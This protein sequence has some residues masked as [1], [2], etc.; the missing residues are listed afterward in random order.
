L[1]ECVFSDDEIV[2]LRAGDAVEKVCRERP[3][4]LVPYIDRLLEEVSTIKQ[5]SVQW[6]LA[7]IVR[8]TP[9]TPKQRA[10]GIKVLKQMLAETN[11]WIV[12]QHALITLVMF[13]D[14]DDGLR[15][16]LIPQLKHYQ[17]DPRRSVARRASKLLAQL[18]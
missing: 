14:D 5:P 7:Q 15:S 12:I 18:E 10:S 11:D 8:E 13:A 6:H 2:R 3:E 1:F 16:W 9:L 4:L 17:Q